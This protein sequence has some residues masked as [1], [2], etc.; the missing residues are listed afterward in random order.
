LFVSLEA[1]EMKHLISAVFVLVAASCASVI[2]AQSTDSWIEVSPGD[3]LFRVSMPHKPT[4]ERERHSY[5]ELRVDG[6]QYLA[7]VDGASYA[8]WSFIDISNHPV[9]TGDDAYLDNCAD[10]VWESILKLARDKL[11]NDAVVRSRMTYIKE[12]SVKPLPPGR[13]YSITIGD[14]TGTLRFFVSNPR[15]YVLLA[16]NIP[17][18]PWDRERFFQSFEI[19]PGE[20][21]S[22]TLNADRPL[23]GDPI[24]AV[25]K[26]EGP[27]YN[28]VFS[29][30][31]TTERARI[32]EK[33]EPVYTESARKYGVQGPIVLRAVLSKDGRVTNIYVV[34]K[35]PHGLTQSAIAAAQQIKFTPATKDGHPV[36]QYVQLEYNFNVY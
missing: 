11:P 30:R 18:G 29:S 22:A 12:L 8:L 28:R 16:M 17:K 20:T 35:L 2:S 10:L 26:E 6:R 4:Q 14:L 34:R 15:I 13:E 5:G 7:P 27:D 9:V 25:G 3:E 31:E 1:F 23:I 36:S 32:V 21:G 33:P 19:K 24:R